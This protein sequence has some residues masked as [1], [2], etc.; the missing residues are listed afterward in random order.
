MLQD[1]LIDVYYARKMGVE[2]TGGSSSNLV[3]SP[4]PRSAEEIIASVERGIYVT[5]MLGGNSDTTRGDFSHG[6]TGFA[7]EKGKPT[8]TLAM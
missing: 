7:I 5:G 1:Y 3:I 2:P 8:P 6:I 4:G